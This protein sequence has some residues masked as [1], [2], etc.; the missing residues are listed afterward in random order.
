[1]LIGSLVRGGAAGAI[2]T[3]LMDLVTTS[4]QQQQS[5]EDA[6]REK[7]ARPNGKGSVMNLVDLLERRLAIG[8]DERSRATAATVI[9]YGLGVLPGA[10]YAVARERVPGL[11]TGR[12]LVFGGLLFLVNDEFLNTALGLAAP[13]DAYPASTHL[14]GLVGHLVLGVATDVGIDVTGG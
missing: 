12:G 7:A 8:L 13:P 5:R 11:G 10:L 6:E 14:R 1:L 2:A 9:H 4:L 3:R